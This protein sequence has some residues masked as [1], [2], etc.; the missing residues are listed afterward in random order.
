MNEPQ[1]EVLKERTYFAPANFEAG[2]AA[3]GTIQKQDNILKYFNFDPAKMDTIPKDH[4]LL[5]QPIYER[6]KKK[7]D[8][9]QLNG[10]IVAHVPDVK[11]VAQGEKGQ[12]YLQEALD[13]VYARRLKQ[14]IAQSQASHTKLKLP[15]TLDEFIESD[16]RDNL[17]QDL[18]QSWVR[19]LKNNGGTLAL[20]SQGILKN[21]LMSASFAQSFAPRIPQS[22]WEKVLDRMT[23]EAKTANLDA[24]VLASWKINRNSFAIEEPQGISLD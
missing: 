4:G 18:M 9:L 20:L 17:F 8:P 13:E 2:K 12:T 23:E 6:A 3:V 22:D 19:K 14:D 1:L 16:R 7:G 21:A 10:I 11:L 15:E 24:S 5:V